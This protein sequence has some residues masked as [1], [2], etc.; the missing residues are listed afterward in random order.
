VQSLQ[1]QWLC[2]G[3]SELHRAG[4]R[5]REPKG[6]QAWAGRRKPVLTESAAESRPLRETGVRVKRRCKRPPLRT[7]RSGGKANPTWS[8]IKYDAGKATRLY[9]D[10][11]MGI[12]ISIGLIAI[13]P[14]RRRPGKINDHRAGSARLWISARV[15]THKIRLIAWPP[16]I[17]SYRP[18]GHYRHK[19][20]APAPESGVSHHS[21]GS[22]R[23]VCL[24]ESSA[25]RSSGESGAGHYVAYLAAD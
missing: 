1:G 8:K 10:T 11:T 4:C 16:E 9:P 15:P 24:P 22:R 5:S 3:K 6:P 13:S 21:Y 23:F 25:F 7:A 20:V 12:G 17:H 14:G 18:H 2:R 19:S